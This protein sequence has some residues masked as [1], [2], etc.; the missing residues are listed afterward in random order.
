MSINIATLA[1][2][3]RKCD[4]RAFSNFLKKS[5][6][7]FPKK[8]LSKFHQEESHNRAFFNFVFGGG[9][10]QWHLANTTP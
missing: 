8:E 9:I 1:T 7:N 2:E 3:N 6:T 10:L 4:K 5:F